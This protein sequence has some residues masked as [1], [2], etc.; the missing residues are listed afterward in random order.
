M[1]GFR[2]HLNTLVSRCNYLFVVCVPHQFLT[3]IVVDRPVDT[4]TSLVIRLCFQDFPFVEMEV[5]T[6]N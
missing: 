5:N 3:V 2:D 1:D 4:G 6:V